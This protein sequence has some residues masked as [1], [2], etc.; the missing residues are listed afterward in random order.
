MAADFGMEAVS[1]IEGEGAVGKIDNVAF[2]SVDENFISEE[3]E[4]QFV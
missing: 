1:K 3:I 2:W 4:F